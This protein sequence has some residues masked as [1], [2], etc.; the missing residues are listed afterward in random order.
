LLTDDFL[1][2]SYSFIALVRIERKSSEE[3]NYFAFDGH[4]KEG[5]EYAK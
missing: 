5:K 1:L 2:S 4:I 3:G